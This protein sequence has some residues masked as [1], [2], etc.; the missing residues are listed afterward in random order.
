[1]QA[2]EVQGILGLALSLVKLASYLHTFNQG[3]GPSGAEGGTGA[4]PAGP[5][6]VASA[7]L[8]KSRP[9]RM[10]GSPSLPA[11][12]TTILLLFERASSRVATI[13]FHFK[14]CSEM[15]SLTMS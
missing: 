11:P 15:P 3:G 5:G 4:D 14:Y 10:I 2:L 6:A 7:D 8:G 12:I 1:M 13:P 9:P